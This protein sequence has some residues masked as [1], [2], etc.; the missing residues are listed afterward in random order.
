VTR[1]RGSRC[2]R[3][4]GGGGGY[5]SYAG[6]GAHRRD[7]GETVHCGLQRA[8]TTQSGEA[9][10]VWLCMQ[11]SPWHMLASLNFLLLLLLLLLVVCYTSE[12]LNSSEDYHDRFAY[13]NNWFSYTRTTSTAANSS[14]RGAPRPG[15]RGNSSWQVG[16]EIT[17]VIT[18]AVVL[19][20]TQLR[21]ALH[22]V[23][24]GRGIP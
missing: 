3:A 11:T 6:L 22:Q 15:L 12:A 24:R 13:L 20:H 9:S 1:R 18:A 14:I 5:G 23:A 17:F 21:P 8:R 16:R 7:E 19:L 4:G 2:G 10:W